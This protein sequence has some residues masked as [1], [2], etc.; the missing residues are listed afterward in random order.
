MGEQYCDAKRPG[1]VKGWH[2][3]SFFASTIHQVAHTFEIGYK[4][5]AR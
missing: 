2:R 5:N 4:Y 1:K 3:A